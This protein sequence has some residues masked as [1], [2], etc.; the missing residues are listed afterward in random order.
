[1][2]SLKD[3]RILVTPRSFARHDP[4]LR[5]ELEEQV[6]SVVYNEEGRP[7]T[8]DE[9]I[10]VIS[11]CDGYIAGLDEINASVIDAALRLKVIARYGTGIDNVDLAA[12]ERKGIAVCS[13][14]G[15]N[16][17]SV[18]EL[19]VGFMLALA[20]QLC[21]ASSATKSGS[22]GRIDGTALGGK[23]VGLI[24]FGAIGSAVAGMLRG[25]NCRVSAY[26]PFPNGDRAAELNVELV[27]LEDVQRQ[28]DILSLHCPLTDVTR[29]F[30]DA[31]F[32]SRMKKGAFLI[33]TA[34]GELVDEDALANALQGGHLAGAAL[35]VFHQQP[36]TLANPLLELPQVIAT[37]HMGSHTDGAI[38]AMGWQA[39]N[40][41]LNV[42]KGLEPTNRVV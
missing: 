6:G 5:E 11:D 36:P 4:A 39:L 27:P 38:N 2:T 9:L 19:T 12:A 21:R 16:T 30:V 33:N 29:N 22:W 28:S 42:L 1:M 24:G 10:G 13:T 15:A 40:D 35:D 26:D 23:S 32:L 17:S 25:F 20:R 41:C 34:R 37:P 7:L 8:A 31:D 14:L 3:R 18:A